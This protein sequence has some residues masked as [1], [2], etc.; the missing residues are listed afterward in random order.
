MYIYMGIYSSCVGIIIVL[1]LIENVAS[2]V[3]N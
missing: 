1:F 2:M 3:C